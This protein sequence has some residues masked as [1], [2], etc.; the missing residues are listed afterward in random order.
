MT[1]QPFRKN[2]DVV[3][4]WRPVARVLAAG[5]LSMP[6]K[7]AEAPNFSIPNE[8]K[9]R[10]E[11][12]RRNNDVISAAELVETAIVEGMESEAERAARA[13][14]AENSPATPLVQKQAAMLLG[15][16]GV[17]APEVREGVRI[18]NLR[19]HVYR[20]PDDAFSWADLALGFVTFGKKDSAKRAMIVALQ[21]APFNRHILRSAARMYLHLGDPERAHDLL[22]NNAATKSD[23]WLVAGEIALSAAA[24][25]KPSLMKVGAAIL[26]NGDFQPLHVSELASAI[27]TVHLRDGNRKARK[28]FGKSLLDPTGNSLAQA[29][30]ANPHLGGEIVS[31]RQIEHVPDSGEARAFHAYW[32]GDFDRMR[33]VCEQWMTEEP[34]SSRP[35]IA[36]SMAAITNDD[37]Q[38][39]LKIARDGLVVEPDST[40][41]RNHLAYA[42]IANSDYKEAT[43]ILRQ[44]LAKHPND[45]SVGFLLATTGMLALRQGDIE[46][47]IARYQ[48]AMTLFKRQGNQASEASAAAF[49]ALEAARAGSEKSDAFIKQAEELTKDLRYA[50]E[51]KVILERAKRWSAAVRHRQAMLDEMPVHWLE[52]KGAENGHGSG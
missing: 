5:E 25:R 34:F 43:Q 42:L 17:H 28:L 49:L 41:L 36:G 40:A 7:P 14:I 50:P 20:F 2:R 11:A 6:N 10:L 39:G 30:W 35:Y 33:I 1:A 52:T 46:T 15:R 18:G 8:L 47:G 24:G 45:F 22:K 4:R 29:E 19:Q 23:P 31:P 9:E 16:L 32:E 48:S 3:P 38:L 37:I 27:G 26:E 51:A 13:L 12:W 44:T 21:L